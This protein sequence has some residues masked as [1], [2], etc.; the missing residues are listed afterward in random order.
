M[1]FLFVKGTA[2]SGVERLVAGAQIAAA[3]DTLARLRSFVDAGD[4]V[5]ATANAELAADFSAQGLRV[6][7]DPPD[8]NFHFG[9]RL[10]ALSDHCPARAALYIGGGSGALMG[11]ADWR[12]MAE[13]ILKERDHAITNNYFSC[14]LI[15]W[16]PAD[17]TRRIPPPELD[18]DLAFRLGTLGGLQVSVLPKNA[19]TQLDIDT[20]TDLMTLSLHPGVGPALHGLLQSAQLDMT[21]VAK[22]R[23]LLRDPRSHLLISG[24]VS[25]GMMQF[26]E[27][28]TPCQWRVFSEERGMRASG[29]QARGEVRSLLGYY[30]EGQSPAS[31]F[32]SLA[33]LANGLVMDSRVLFAHR[34]LRPS[35]DDRFNSDLI[36]P[37]RIADP[38]IRD[39]TMAARDASIPVLLGG[40]SLVSGGMYGL[41]ESR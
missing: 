24:R 30:L 11:T 23:A 39:F 25:A 21:R 26:L 8:L 28:A 2:T 34:Q 16:T 31:F 32:S 33:T 20:P 1:V 37:G 3:R 5:I 10:A 22:I 41:V 7:L 27:Q 29:R 36:Q 15:A 12:H 38:F 17:A 13:R 18:N 14:D 9:A 40:H 4:I 6:E 35:I 19:A